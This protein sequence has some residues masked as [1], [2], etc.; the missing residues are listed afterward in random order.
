MAAGLALAATSLQAASAVGGEFKRFHR[1]VGIDES[2]QER[3]GNGAG[4]RVGVIDTDIDV[5][6]P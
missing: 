6:H 2:L 5:D 3:A 4:V 1:H